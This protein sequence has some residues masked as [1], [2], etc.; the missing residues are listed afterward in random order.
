[1]DRRN[2]LHLGAMTGVASLLPAQQV[3]ATA[4]LIITHESLFYPYDIVVTGGRA[5]FMAWRVNYERIRL[6]AADDIAVIRYHMSLDLY[7]ILDVLERKLDLKPTVTKNVIERLYEIPPISYGNL[8]EKVKTAVDIPLIRVSTGDPARIVSKVGLAWGGLG[9]FV[10]IAHMQ[11]L[12]D[13]GC[14]VIIAGETD[15]YA[16]RF[17]KEAGLDIIETS[18][19]VSENFGIEEFIGTLRRDLPGANSMFYENKMPY[20]II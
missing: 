12:I 16:I 7:C 15:N 11:A 10:N 19:E 6:L 2:F 14:E 5:D 9:L 1:M 17:A 4:D 20:K 3:Q 18:H 8:I 13:M